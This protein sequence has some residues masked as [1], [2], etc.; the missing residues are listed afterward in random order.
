MMGLVAAVAEPKAAS[1]A[2]GLKC[3]LLREPRRRAEK[4]PDDELDGIHVGGIT[5]LVEG[6]VFGLDLSHQRTAA[7]LRSPGHPGHKP[8]SVGRSACRVALSWTHRQWPR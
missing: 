8:P 7:S 4:G 5:C 1:A 6:A 2:A 3:P